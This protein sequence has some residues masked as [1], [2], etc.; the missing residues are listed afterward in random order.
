MRYKLQIK[1]MNIPNIDINKLLK[2]KKKLT[3]AGVAAAILLLII[4]LLFVCGPLCRPNK[5]LNAGEPTEELIKRLDGLMVSIINSKNSYAENKGIMG[6][7]PLEKKAGAIEEKA[8]KAN[9]LSLI[10]IIWDKEQP[11]ALIDDQLLVVGD[12]IYGFKIIEIKE[13]GITI[14]DEK[15]ERWVI[16]LL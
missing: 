5:N 10:G 7:L 16:N 4:I 9:D 12:Y 8:A 15:G 1:H 11:V 14:E 2:D 6:T 3:I 13:E